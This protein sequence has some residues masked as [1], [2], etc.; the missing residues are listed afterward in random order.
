VDAFL[1]L[2]E[3]RVNPWLAFPRL[4]KSRGQ[5]SEP[6]KNPR[7]IFQGLE[8]LVLFFSIPGKSTGSGFQS[9][10]NKTAGAGPLAAPAAARRAVQ[11]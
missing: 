8:S 4:G 6:W 9:L 2:R 10:E 5:V 1:L 11:K 7:G 3:I